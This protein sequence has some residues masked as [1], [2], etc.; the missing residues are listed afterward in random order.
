MIHERS[1]DTILTSS[2]SGNTLKKNSESAYF[3]FLLIACINQY[4]GIQNQL[5]LYIF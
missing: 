4:L 3:K 5:L 1:P 2:A